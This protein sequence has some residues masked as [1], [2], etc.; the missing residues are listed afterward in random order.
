MEVI[1][2]A[3]TGT[4]VVS[5]AVALSA[6][7]PARARPGSCEWNVYGGKLA[8]AASCPALRARPLWRIYAVEEIAAEACLELLSVGAL[9]KAEERHVEVVLTK[10]VAAPAKG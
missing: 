4:D 7:K 2:A 6:R 3:A 8:A 1:P 9:R 5:E 10:R